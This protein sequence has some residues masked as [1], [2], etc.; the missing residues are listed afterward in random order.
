MYK[1]SKTESPCFLE[2]HKVIFGIVFY[3]IH[4]NMNMAI[5]T[6]AVK[7]YKKQFQFKCNHL[8]YRNIRERIR[9]ARSFLIVGNLFQSHDQNIFF[10]RYQAA[11]VNHESTYI[12]H[13]QCYA[14]KFTL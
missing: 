4:Q 7:D 5:I 1:S 9:T 11:S 8:N 3:C 13:H 10:D 2:T 12:F 14:Y 6:C